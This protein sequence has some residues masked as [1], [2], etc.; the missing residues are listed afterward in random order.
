MRKNVITFICS[1][2]VCFV[3]SLLFTACGNRNKPENG[4]TVPEEK[5]SSAVEQVYTI[6]TDDCDLKYP[7]KWQP[8]VKTTI[9]EDALNV[10]RFMHIDGTPLFDIAFGEADGVFLG[11][12]AGK[13]GA[14]AVYY[15][16]YNLDEKNQNY[17]DQL[18][19]QDAADTILKYLKQ[20]YGSAEETATENASNEEVFGIQT[21]VT[22]LYYPKIWEDAM[23]VEENGKTVS[24]SYG[25]IKLFDIC[26]EQCDGVLLGIYD[27]TPIYVISYDVEKD[28]LSSE[29]YRD[30]CAM[31]DDVNVILEHLK[32][33][34]KFE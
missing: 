24:F 32:Q 28:R 16:G 25:E 30:I 3:L 4:N 7:Q 13:R 14:V 22:T 20:D 10:V 5:E 6:E 8:L 27:G 1:L 29:Q 15:I 17:Y 23:T 12:F 18:G 19:M 34:S 2:I 26:F 33:D 21:S 9:P 31:Q 11:K